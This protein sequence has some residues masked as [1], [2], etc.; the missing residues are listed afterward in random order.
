MCKDLER[1]Q[2]TWNYLEEL[3]R[4][5]SSWKDMKGLDRNGKELKYLEGLG[6]T[7]KDLKGLERIWKYLK[8]LERTWKDLKGHERIWKNLKK[9]NELQD[10]E[11]Q[12]DRRQKTEWLTRPVIQRHA[13]LKNEHVM[14]IFMS[15]VGTKSQFLKKFQISKSCSI[16]EIWPWTFVSD[17]NTYIGRNSK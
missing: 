15:Q 1:L 5:R 7:C 8:V 13:P 16:F 14:L 10:L 3:G 2:R 12:T 17:L 4:T 11:R 9:L 6:S